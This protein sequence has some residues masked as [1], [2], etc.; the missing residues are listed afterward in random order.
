RNFC[1]SPCGISAL[2]MLSTSRGE[3]WSI[4]PALTVNGYLPGPLVCTGAVTQTI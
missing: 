1:W 2:N 3:K 4:L